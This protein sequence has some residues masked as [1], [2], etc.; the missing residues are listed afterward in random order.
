MAI[1]LLDG[2]VCILDSKS[3]TVGA[4]FFITDEGLIATCVHVVEATGA[5][6]GDVV[7]VASCG[8]DDLEAEVLPDAYHPDTDVA[9]LRLSG[10]LSEACKS[11]HLAQSES[12]EGVS[13]RAFGY[14]TVGEMD[15]LWG[16]GELVG[17]VTE[18]GRPILQLSSTEITKGFSG[19]PVREQ[20][21]GC[22]VGMVASVTVPDRLERLSDVAFAVPAETLR[23]LCPEPLHLYSIQ[24]QCP[25]MVSDLPDDFV[26]RP[27]EFNLLVE[28]LLAE[29]EGL[30]GITTALRGAGGYGKTTLAQALC[31]DDRVRAAFPDGILWVTLGQRPNIEG[32]ALK[33][34]KALTGEHPALVDTEDAAQELDR[35]LGNKRCLLVI[36]DVWNEVHM[37]PFLRGGPNCTRLITT[38]NRNTLPP[39]VHTV[40]VDAMQPNEAV[41]LLGAGLDIGQRGKNM[42]RFTKLAARLGK[43]PLLLRLVNGVLRRRFKQG[44]SLADAHEYVRQVLERRGL[45][46]FDARDAEARDQ[47]VSLTMDMSLGLLNEEER[48]RYHELSVFPKDEDIPLKAI[49]RLWGATGSM[50]EFEVEELCGHLFDLSLLRRFDLSARMIA[51]H[52]VV[53][54][55]LARQLEDRLFTLHNRLMKAYAVDCQH[56]ADGAPRWATGPND[57][58]YFHRLVYH[59]AEAGRE[60]ELTDLLL[61]FDWLQTKL[62]KIDVNAL[63]TDYDVALSRSEDEALQLVQDAIRL[64]AHILAENKTQLWVQLYGRLM[65]H[66]NPDIQGILIA[67]LEF[68]WLRPLMPSLPQAGGPLLRVLESRSGPIEAVAVMANESRAVSVS[69]DK[70]LQVWEL[71]SGTELNVLKGHTQ[72]VNAV[73]IGDGYAVSASDDHTLRVWDLEN[74]KRIYTLEEHTDKVLAV[75]ATPDRRLVVSGS[76]DETLK[77]WDPEYGEELDTLEGHAASA[78]A[79][80]PDGRI[81]ISGS[82]GGT[83]K[84]WDL[85]HRSELHTLEGHTST[86]WAVAVTPDGRR[87]VSASGDQTIRVWDSENG[88]ELS[89]LTGHEGKVWAVAVTPDGKRAISGSED[90]TL[91]VWDLESGDLL[92]TLKEHTGTVWAV[93]VMGQRRVISASEDGTLRMW[94]ISDARLKRGTELSTVEGHKR[95]VNEIMVT[96]DSRCAI[97]TSDDLRLW[98]LEGGARLHTLEGHIRDN[99]QGGRQSDEKLDVNAVVVTPDGERAISGA[100]DG[101]LK[102]WDISD[103]DSE[104]VKALTTLRSHKQAI[105]ALAI[106]SDGQFVVSASNDKTLKVWDI[107]DT[108]LEKG[109]ELHRLEGHVQY[110]NAVAITSDGQFVVSASNDK[111]LKVW[112]LRRG[113]E[114]RTL[115]GHKK[116]VEAVAVTPNGQHVVS[117]SR[118]ETLKVW[119]LESGAELR[120]LKGHSDRVVAVAV[121]C[122]GH[123]ATSGSWDGT[124]RIWDLKSESKPYT[125]RGHTGKV[126]TIAIMPD[127]KC[128]ISGSVD[129]TLRMWDLESATCIATFAIE[130]VLRSCAVAPDSTIVVGGASGQVHI[131]RLEKCEPR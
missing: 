98:D 123:I 75:A 125:L 70:F 69:R 104:S 86:V 56:G 50:G 41:Q 1:D 120:T 52:D 113:I 34:L 64:S 99:N 6:P 74:G 72:S 63:L 121:T 37:R 103:A 96:P 71:N 130:S 42:P 60:E 16:T 45:T 131:L 129:K 68:P 7:R 85:E 78:V 67:P 65:V 57:G 30:V 43:W 48:S 116:F 26:P 61:D 5:G 25:F 55:Y 33:I 22:V 92:H 20:Q 38:R 101:T 58:Y 12:L 23:D 11:V 110:V 18:A 36:D 108:G 39:D 40:D 124:L 44:E 8:H 111:T 80:T 28:R 76:L 27:E 102:V 3:E 4:G 14:P 19:G 2:V 21:S 107:S 126:L 114:L 29:D 17:P 35:A 13:V 84:V 89:T 62:R 49:T 128:A 54:D 127:G 31:H 51:L 83:L 24:P 91:K 79:I 77:V 15:G 10:Q 94:D 115:E 119:N 53:Q 97:S 88:R 87:A 100:S 46:G 66:D 109:Q 32:N 106:T 105:N 47:A 93:E 95:D 73:A 59:L 82:L 112:D 9:F 117:A 81:V 118:D 122:D 90:R